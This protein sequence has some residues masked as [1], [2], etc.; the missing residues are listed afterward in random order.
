MKILNKNNKL[1]RSKLFID[2]KIYKQICEKHNTNLED[3]LKRI[4][5]IISFPNS[6]P[7]ME[8]VSI[9]FEIYGRITKIVK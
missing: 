7:D 6:V 1:K 4:E 5:K 9:M 8:D 3:H 2:K